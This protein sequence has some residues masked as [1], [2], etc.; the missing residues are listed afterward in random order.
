MAAVELPPRIRKQSIVENAEKARSDRDVLLQ[1]GFSK[2][3]AEKALAS[4]GHQGVDI[5]SNWLLSHLNDPTLDEVT[6]RDY[7]VYLCPTGPLLK[8]LQLFWYKSR[9]QTEW[10]LAHNYLPHITLCSFFKVPDNKVIEVARNIRVIADRMAAQMP[11]KLLL[12]YYNASNFI[13]IFLN[14]QNVPIM[15]QVINEFAAEAK[16]IGVD[17]EPHKKELHISLAYQFKSEHQ[18]TLES[19]SKE[20]DLKSEAHWDLRLYSRDPRCKDK[21]VRRV[22]YKHKPQA[23]DEL[24]LIHGDFIFADPADIEKS[25]D[26]WHLGTSWLTGLSGMVPLNYTECTSQT[27][28]WTLHRS[29]TMIGSDCGMS[30]LNGVQDGA[31]P[32]SSHHHQTHVDKLMSE[33]PNN[34]LY[35]KVNKVADHGACSRPSPQVHHGPRQIYII[36]H[37]ERMDFCFGRD[38]VLNCFD[39]SGDYIRKDLNMPKHLA[40]RVGGKHDFRH[41]SPL[42]TQG[43][44]QAFVTGEAM[45]EKDIVI[46]HVYSS[47]S[48]RCLQTAT[49]ILRGL[50]TSIPIR[51]EPCLFEWCGWYTN[52]MPKFLATPQE[53]IDYNINVDNTYK[54]YLPAKNLTTEESVVD[55]YSRSYHFTKQA[56]HRHHADG[57]NILIVGHAGSLEVCSRQLIGKT[58][59]S[60]NDFHAIVRNVPYCGVAVCQEDK[61]SKWQLI[62]SPILSF[63]HSDNKKLMPNL[64]EM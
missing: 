46:S 7:I 1:M 51:V 29:I 43:H 15:K 11:Q 48:L 4:T 50:K 27:D 59:R 44:H 47:P 13:G 23:P 12:D 5:A 19:L 39:Q 52:Q 26:Q 21:Q 55:L 49:Q 3:R 24:D 30:T 20:I 45:H 2:L 25:R 58:A 16:K 18:K 9:A 22:R 57:E 38:W 28:M 37:G 41:D 63:C 35:A 31:T 8:Q 36:R 33:I 32:S 14:K 42:T 56:L 60:A 61:K 6:P 34:A 54:P 53:Y 64:L 62:E 10:N 40:K 17:V